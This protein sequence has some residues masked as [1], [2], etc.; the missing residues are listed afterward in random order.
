[1]APTVQQSVNMGTAAGRS[2]GVERQPKSFCLL[3]FV[4]VN[5]VWSNGG[6]RKDSSV[7]E[8]LIRK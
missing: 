7:I 2:C 1:M 4:D 3:L 6:E 5:V 8:Q